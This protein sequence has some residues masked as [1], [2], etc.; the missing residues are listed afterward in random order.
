[1]DPGARVRGRAA[2]LCLLVWLAA[3]GE[4]AQPAIVG[5][6]F[7]CLDP[8]CAQIGGVG[9][10]FAADGAFIALYPTAQVLTPGGRYCAISNP[11]LIYRYTWDGRQLEIR[12][13]ESV[14]KRYDFDVAGAR[15]SVIDRDSGA[16]SSMKRLQAPRQ[17]GP[18]RERTP[19]VCPV[20][21]MR[22][23]GSECRVSWTC[24]GGAHE[25][26]CAAGGSCTCRAGGATG[27]SFSEA[28]LCALGA[29][30]LSE[31][32]ARVNAGCGW[33]LSLLPF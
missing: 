25:I 12:E 13:D 9:R 5:D 33:Q 24:D 27:R 1:M 29:A 21:A 18:C 16:T 17:S 28:G 30:G 7:G 10:R 32:Y 15:A 22:D 8:Q 23:E 26:R 19:W 20:F 3:C 4:P 2:C 6:W 14:R 31:L 11:G